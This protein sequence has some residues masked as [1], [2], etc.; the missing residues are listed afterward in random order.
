MKKWVHKI[1]EWYSS[2]KLREKTTALFAIILC[3]Y[4]LLFLGLYQFGIKA[5]MK[6]YIYNANKDVLN[7]VEKNITDSFQDSSTVSKWIKL[8]SVISHQIPLI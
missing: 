8:T 6:E 1:R 5:N 3:T 4:I 7:S 2:R